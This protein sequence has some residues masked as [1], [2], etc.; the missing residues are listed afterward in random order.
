MFVGF[1]SAISEAM[2]Y[3]NWKILDKE[4]A[5]KQD[6]P[7]KKSS[8]T[9]LNSSVTEKKKVKVISGEKI[10]YEVTSSNKDILKTLRNYTRHTESWSVLGHYRQYKS[11]KKIWINPHVKGTGKKEI[12]KYIIK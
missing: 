9:S 11:G 8:S 10:I 12:T 4:V 2:A 6:T 7:S 1:Q 5:Y 3:L